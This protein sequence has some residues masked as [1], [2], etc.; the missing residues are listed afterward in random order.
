MDPIFAYSIP[1]LP[2]TAIEKK[3]PEAGQN[4]SPHKTEQ[5]ANTEDSLEPEVEKKKNVLSRRERKF[6]KGIA[7]FCGLTKGISSAVTNF[8][9]GMI[10]GVDHALHPDPRNQAG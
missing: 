9:C 6:R 7:K 8:P 2:R 3:A 5:P 10:E 1:T 4:D